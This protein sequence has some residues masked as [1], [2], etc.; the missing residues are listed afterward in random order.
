MQVNIERITKTLN[1]TAEQAEAVKTYIDK[2]AML[3][4]TDASAALVSA[5]TRSVHSHLL[6]SAPVKRTKPV[7]PKTPK[8][9]K[10]PKASSAPKAGSK[11]A[12]ALTVYNEMIVDGVR[13]SRKDIISAIANS[14][15]IEPQQAAGYYQSCKKKVGA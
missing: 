7:T 13:C 10:T 8:A 6:R 12:H 5:I 2:G 4:W 11:I 14:M 3:S 9:V 15:Q 1:C